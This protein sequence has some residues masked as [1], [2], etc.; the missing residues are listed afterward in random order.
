MFI[1]DRDLQRCAFIAACGF[2]VDVIKLHCSP[3]CAGQYVDSPDTR[4][5]VDSYNAKRPSEIPARTVLDCYG[6]LIAQA[7]DLKAGRIGG[8]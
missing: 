1:T 6:K 3:R 2:Q 4:A 8:V 7:K 5:L